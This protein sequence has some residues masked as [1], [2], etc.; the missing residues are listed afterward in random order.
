MVGELTHIRWFDEL[1]NED[2]GEVGGKN[3]SLGE[4]IQRLQEAGI[5]VPAGFATTADAYRLFLEENDLGPRIREHID[6]LHSGSDLQQIGEAIRSLFRE[7]ELPKAVAEDVL[8]AYEEL[9]GRYDEDRT[10]VAARSSATAE[11]LPEA[12]FAGQQETYLNVRGDEHLLASV[13]DCYASLFTDRAIAYREE[14]GFDHFEV[15]LSVGI[16]KMV[17]STVAGRA[18][19]SRS[20]PGPASPVS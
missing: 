20:T 1:T 10:D 2:V 19:P 11:D 18:S 13:V 14:Q 6:E 12:S 3:A 5:R 15:A 8:Q 17:R 7:Q 9:S 4:M 16:Q